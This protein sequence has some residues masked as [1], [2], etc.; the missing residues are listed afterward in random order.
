MIS[1]L[2]GGVAGPDVLA[3]IGMVIGDPP[4]TLG[5][6]GLEPSGAQA[7]NVVAARMMQ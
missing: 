6:T 7:A 3:L 1:L 2:K 4:A 5:A